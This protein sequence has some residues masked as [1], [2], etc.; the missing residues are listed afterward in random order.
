MK[1]NELT[2]M[3]YFIWQQKLDNIQNTTY[4]TN[5]LKNSTENNKLNKVSECAQIYR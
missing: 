4:Y 1:M 5:Q 3:V 2:L